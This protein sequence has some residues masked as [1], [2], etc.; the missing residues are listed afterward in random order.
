MADETPDNDYDPEEEFVFEDDEETGV[1]RSTRRTALPAPA[2]ASKLPWILALLL[3]LLLL[4]ASG[5]AWHFYNEAQKPGEG[6]DLGPL[7]AAL[8]GRFGDVESALREGDLAALAARD[9]KLKA[10]LLRMLADGATEEEWTAHLAAAEKTPYAGLRGAAIVANQPPVILGGPGGSVG[11]GTL[12]ER[13]IAVSDPE[14]DRIDLVLEKGPSG[15]RIER[16]DGEF[17]LV[18]QAPG[19]ASGEV[20]FLLAATDSAGNK[21]DREVKVKVLRNAAPQLLTSQLYYRPYV[22]FTG[23]IEA[24]DGDGDKVSFE[25]IDAPDRLRLDAVSG[26]IAWEPGME[27]GDKNVRLRLSDGKVEVEAT[28]RLIER[29]GSGDISVRIDNPTNGQRFSTRVIDLNGQITS[30]VAVEKVNVVLNGVEQRLRLGRDGS[31]SEKVVLRA[32]RNE[33]IVKAEAGEDYGAAAVA[34][35]C[36]VKPSRILATLTWDQEYDADLYVDQPNGE[37]V[38]YSYKNTRLGGQL[39]VDNRQGYGPENYSITGDLPGGLYRIRVN[40]FEDNDDQLG[41]PL[42]QGPCEWH[43]RVIL[44]EGTANERVQDF[45]GTMPRVGDWEEVVEL[46]IDGPAPARKPSASLG[47]RLDEEGRIASV[48]QHWRAAGLPEQ[49]TIR[50]I[51]ITDAKGNGVRAVVRTQEDLEVILANLEIGETV[52]VECRDRSGG[53]VTPRLLEVIAP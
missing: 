14:G 6:T 39:D 45:E 32:G 30:R 48:S 15:A 37:I 16:R 33:L 18:W 24:R 7:E 3:L 10:D 43:V 35:Q 13:G 31:F 29:A 23:T 5:A 22:P 46:Q 19:S 52:Q 40:F 50:Y 28:L 4:A 42:A 2:P 47:V 44:D 20:S 1:S 53:A 49:G 8:Q 21:V 17:M 27:R 38:Y 26:I 12:L 51:T 11:A 25:L 41:K 34:V 36:G 9:A